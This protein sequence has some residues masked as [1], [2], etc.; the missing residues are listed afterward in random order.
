VEIDAALYA[1]T[2][3]HFIIMRRKSL[4]YSGH[5]KGTPLGAQREERV[6]TLNTHLDRCNEH[7]LI[8]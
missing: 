7:F 6:H 8:G 5:P 1:E 2:A 3:E 4:N